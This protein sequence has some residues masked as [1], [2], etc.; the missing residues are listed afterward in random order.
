M[1][2]ALIAFA[3]LFAAIALFPR[4]VGAAL[5]SA[6]SGLKQFFGQIVASASSGM[7]AVKAIVG[8]PGAASPTAVLVG[9]ISACAAFPIARSEFEVVRRSL[10]LVWPDEIASDRIALSLVVVTFTV[11]VLMH[12]LRGRLSRLAFGSV[13]LSLISVSASLS[14]YR[15]LEIEKTSIVSGGQAG[16][17]PSDTGELTIG[18]LGAEPSEASTAPL[19]RQP[20][21]L[22]AVLAGLLALLLSLGGVV[23]GFG[24]TALGSPA[25]IAAAAF[26]VLVV[27]WL[28]MAAGQVI[29]LAVGATQ[30]GMTE[31]L[32]AWIDLRPALVRFIKRL[33]PADWAEEADV[34]RRTRA[35]RAASFA[36]YTSERDTSWQKLKSERMEEISRMDLD[37]AFALTQRERDQRSVS[38]ALDAS[39]SLISDAHLEGVREV[40]AIVG[41][42]RREFIELAVREAFRGLSG[43]AARLPLQFVSMLFWPLDRIWQFMGESFGGPYSGTE[44]DDGKPHRDSSSN[45]NEEQIQ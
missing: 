3:A 37:R 25:M 6:A 33:C 22:A 7:S 13:V 43:R 23:I 32:E 1:E 4:A 8:R 30:A 41:G 21:R 16:S 42:Q 34:W 38:A 39:R 10:Q 26:P 27:L 29:L 45:A 17:S 36:R 5:N 2:P 15:T 9:V 14:Y 24:A 12:V 28:S 44:P 11:G 19:G 40:L 35:E 31:L 20:D 18:G